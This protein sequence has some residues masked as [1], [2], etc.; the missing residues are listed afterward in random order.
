MQSKNRSLNSKGETTMLLLMLKERGTLA[1]SPFSVADFAPKHHHHDLHRSANGST[2]WLQ[3]KDGCKWR[4]AMMFNT[5]PAQNYPPVLYWSNAAATAPPASVTKLPS[6]GFKNKLLF[7]L[8][9]PPPSPRAPL[10]LASLTSP[11]SAQR[12]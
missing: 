5:P 7:F 1:E 2:R 10:S 6:P 9:A 4:M 8:E 3:A 12:K 11:P